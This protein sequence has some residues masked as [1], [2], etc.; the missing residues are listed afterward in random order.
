MGGER[1][2]KRKLMNIS[3]SCDHRVVDG[4]DAASFAQELKKLLEAPARLLAG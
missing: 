1:L 4:W 2:E 3:M